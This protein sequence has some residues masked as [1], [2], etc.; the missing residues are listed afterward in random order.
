MAFNAKN[1]PLPV[2]NSIAKPKCERTLCTHY[3][4]LGHTIDNCYKIPPSYKFKPKSLPT[5]PYV[6]QMTM[7]SCDEPLLIASR[8]SKV[9]SLSALSLALCQKLIFLLSS[10]IGHSSP[11]STSNNQQ[12]G[13]TSWVFSYFLLIILFVPN[14]SCPFVG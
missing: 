3:G 7:V 1:Q 10:Q 13:P 5:P 6:N 2:L 4:L 11:V 8:P 12:S 14:H 9:Y